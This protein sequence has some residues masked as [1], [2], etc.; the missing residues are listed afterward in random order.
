MAPQHSKNL[1]NIIQK[2]LVFETPSKNFNENS[3]L[4]FSTEIFEKHKENCFKFITIMDVRDSDPAIMISSEPMLVE[5][6]CSY[7]LL[8]CKSRKEK[9]IQ[10]CYLISEVVYLP[11]GN[12]ELSSLLKS[13]KAVKPFWK[14][15][16]I[17]VLLKEQFR[18]THSDVDDFGHSTAA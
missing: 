10:F 16:N 5:N 3:Q 14:H 7:F 1:I 8:H 13:L 15:T 6:D 2:P 9:F 17:L 11:A 18:R 4:V 12:I